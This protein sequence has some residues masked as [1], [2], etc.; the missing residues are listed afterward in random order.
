MPDKVI[1]ADID[2]LIRA[3][4][5]PVEYVKRMALEKNLAI[6]KDKADYLLTAD[7]IVSIGAR[8]LGKPKNQV[9][10]RH[11]LELISGRRHSVLTSVVISH[12]DIKLE[13]TVSTSVQFKHMSRLELQFYLSSGEWR[14][15][16]GAYAI[17]GLGSRY[18]KKINGSYTSVVGL[19]AL[20]TINLLSTLNYQVG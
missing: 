8:I 9:E 2:E 3:R 5:K 16:A 6:K 20:E 1:S 7:T 13:K 11:Y 12:L 19:P 17:Q 18:I 14:G 10:A 15:K 4:E